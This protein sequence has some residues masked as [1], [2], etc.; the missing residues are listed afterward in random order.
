M[1]TS[2]LDI[3]PAQSIDMRKVGA[4]LGVDTRQKK[5]YAICWLINGITIVIPIRV[6]MNMQF[7]LASDAEKQ[8][9]AMLPKNMHADIIKPYSPTGSV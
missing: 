7:Q 6:F 1:K 4:L 2:T 3:S 8:M 5:G 9:H